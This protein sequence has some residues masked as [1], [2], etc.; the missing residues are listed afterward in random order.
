MDKKE[1]FETK[2]IEALL[3][4]IKLKNRAL[5]KLIN[6]IEKK[7]KSKILQLILMIFLTANISFAQKLII[8]DD[9]NFMPTST[10][11]LLELKPGSNDKSMMNYELTINN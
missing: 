3:E 4:K 10:N 1:N 2:K 8:S 11:A 5:K 6:E 9:E 7:Q